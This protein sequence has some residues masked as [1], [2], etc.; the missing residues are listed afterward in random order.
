MLDR[1]RR[2]REARDADMDARVLAAI[3]AGHDYGFGI[4]KATGLRAGGLYVALY[5]LERDGKITS[6]WEPDPGGRPPRRL[7]S[8]AELEP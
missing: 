8:V 6:R 2:W 4:A 5:R 1:F 3:R 7:Y